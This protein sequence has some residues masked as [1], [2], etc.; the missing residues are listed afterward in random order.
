M[1]LN[2]AKEVDPE[3]YDLYF[4]C[5][6]CPSCLGVF[7]CRV[8]ALERSLL[9][10]TFVVYQCARGHQQTWMSFRG[11]ARVDTHGYTID[12]QHPLWLDDELDREYWGKNPYLWEQHYGADRF[13]LSG[14]KSFPMGSLGWITR[15]ADNPESTSDCT[16]TRDLFTGYITSMRTTDASSSTYHWRIWW[17]TRDERGGILINSDEVRYPTRK[18]AMKALEIFFK[19]SPEDV[20]EIRWKG[21]LSPYMEEE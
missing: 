20:K 8:N 11:S 19:I 5:P 4:E 18:E 14:P 2:M 15:C 21:N 12:R 3:L 6:Y 9:T 17:D 13:D 10:E 16:V 7:Q 1:A